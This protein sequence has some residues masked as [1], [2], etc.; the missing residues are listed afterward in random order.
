MFTGDAITGNN[1]HANATSYLFELTEVARQIGIPHAYLLGNHDCMPFQ[2][3]AYHSHA[4]EAGHRSTASEHDT[5]SIP[6]AQQ[7]A[8]P[9]TRIG[10]R[11][12]L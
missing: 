7:L 4:K 5:D 8:A 9:A 2:S 10:R 3:M 6:V 12:L 11:E 1:V